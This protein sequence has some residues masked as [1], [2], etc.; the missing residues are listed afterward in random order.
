MLLKMI[1]KS[2]GLLS[3]AEK[4]LELVSPCPQK[5]KDNVFKNNFLKVLCCKND[6]KCTLY[7]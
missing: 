3:A 7:E 6:R 2:N 1:V 5:R 4:Y